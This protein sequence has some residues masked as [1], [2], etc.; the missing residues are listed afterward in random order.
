[1]YNEYEEM[2]KQAYEDAYLDAYEE[3]AKQAYEDAYADAYDEV[4]DAIAKQAE[5]AEFDDMVKMAYDEICGFEKEALWDKKWSKDPVKKQLSWTGI[6]EKTSNALQGAHQRLSQQWVDNA[7]KIYD[8]KA[9]KKSNGFKFGR[10]ARNTLKE[11]KRENK[12]LG[13][14]TSSISTMLNAVPQRGY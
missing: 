14:K 11:L 2:A 9:A 3:M 5:A 7:N 6:S 13:K 1:M 10:E 4:C 12:N 8:L